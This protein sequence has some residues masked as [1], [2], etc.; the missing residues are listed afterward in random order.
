MRIQEV[1]VVGVGVEVE[2]EGCILGAAR[3]EVRMEVVGMG[4]MV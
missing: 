3:G 4:G 1:V 2:V